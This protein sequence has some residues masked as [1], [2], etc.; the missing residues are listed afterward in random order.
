MLR[1]PIGRL[2][3]VDRGRR[4][5][6]SVVTV[7]GVA[8]V[9]GLAGC[10][11]SSSSSSSSTAAASSSAA[12]GS[13]TTSASSGK[14]P[15]VLGV[16]SSSSGPIAS[17][18]G[19]MG[20]TVTAW[21]KWRNAN[22]GID[23]HPVKAI[24]MDDGGNPSTALQ[25]VKQMVTQDHII[26]LM[27][28]SGTESDFGPYTKQVNIPVVGG[29]DA[30]VQYSTLSNWFSLGL[31]TP[32]TTASGLKLAANMG[33][34]KAGVMYCAEVAACSEVVSEVA[35][36]GKPLGVSVASTSSISSTAAD[37]TAQCLKAKGAGANFLFVS[38]A[39][40]QQLNVATSCV[41]QGLKAP[42]VT[43]NININ[44]TWLKV[45]AANGGIAAVPTFPYTDSSNAA[46]QA[47]QSAMKQYA[48]SL[49]SSSQFGSAN[50][51]AWTSGQLFAAAAAA[52]DM[53]NSPSMAGIFKG[54][55]ALKN[56][57]LG[58]LSGPINYVKGANANVKNNC[59][60]VLQVKNGKMTEPQGLKLICYTP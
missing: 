60:F 16:I 17:T 11:S 24:V 38:A 20:P 45:P 27:P 50:A 10:G 40:Q 26:A 9:I 57:T 46:T 36:L 3:D 51:S 52:G 29:L 4:R 32:A 23:G 28:L 58:G 21:A 18:V 5:L 31:N 6:S 15:Y 25:D 56:E 14:V 47:F 53:G 35:G 13:G 54:L 41:Q 37:Y 49:L 7:V 1:N 43:G 19:Q 2:A 33:L 44:N 12:G 34:K 55:Y 59:G 30:A 42:L 8:A 48:P 22:G 39:A